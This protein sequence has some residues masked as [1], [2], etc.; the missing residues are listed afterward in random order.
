MNSAPTS[1]LCN[2]PQFR[3]AFEQEEASSGNQRGLAKKCKSTRPHQVCGMY[4]LVPETSL[5]NKL[6][7]RTRELIASAPGHLTILGAKAHT[8]DHHW[9]LTNE[10]APR[11]QRGVPYA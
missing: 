11:F 3:M 7:P 9:I 10:H 6:Y 8:S 5:E 1:A 2:D 4:F